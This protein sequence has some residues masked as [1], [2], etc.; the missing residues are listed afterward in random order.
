MYA[1]TPEGEALTRVSREDR[2][3]RAD[4]LIAVIEAVKAVGERPKHD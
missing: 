1:A 2:Q 3:I 4:A